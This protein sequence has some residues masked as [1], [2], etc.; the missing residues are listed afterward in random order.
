MDSCLFPSLSKAMTSKLAFLMAS[1]Y[2]V[3]FSSQRVC[4]GWIR[5]TPYPPLIER[6]FAEGPALVSLRPRR[7][8][9]SLWLDTL[10]EYYDLNNQ[11]SF[12]QLFGHLVIGKSKTINA[13]FILCSDSFLRW[14]G[15]FE[16]WGPSILHSLTRSTTAV[17]SFSKHTLTFV[18]L[19]TSS[20]T[21]HSV[22]SILY[23]GLSE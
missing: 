11:D 18:M 7:F 4:F 2:S 23:G 16:C 9:K 3:T 13:P 8:G 14:A 12:E 22:P 5:H 19:F 1:S 10:A 6:L 21:M 20:Q 17:W 15:H